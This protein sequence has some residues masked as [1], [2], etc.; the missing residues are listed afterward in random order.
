V[1]ASPGLPSRGGAFLKIRVPLM[2]SRGVFLGH[3]VVIMVVTRFLGDV[4]IVVKRRRKSFLIRD[5]RS[6]APIAQLDRAT[7]F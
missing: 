1:S 6:L 2:Y 5:L 4:E 3:A 7:D